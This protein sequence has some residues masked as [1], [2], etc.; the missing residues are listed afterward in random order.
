MNN[1]CS[2]SIGHG[3]MPTKNF[4]MIDWQYHLQRIHSDNYEELEMKQQEEAD[5]RVKKVW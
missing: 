3:G 4:S 5:K 1:T 2:E